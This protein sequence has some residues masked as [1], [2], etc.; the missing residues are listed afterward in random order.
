MERKLDNEN[1]RLYVK[2]LW[3][4]CL[5][6]S[7]TRFIYS[8]ENR[9]IIA[10][11]KLTYQKANKVVKDFIE[12]DPNNIKRFP[13][14]IEEHLKIIHYVYS[15]LYPKI[16]NRINNFGVQNKN[17]FDFVFSSW[18]ARKQAGWPISPKIINKLTAPT[19]QM[20]VTQML[21]KAKN[22]K[23]YQNRAEVHKFEQAPINSKLIAE[24]VEV[25]NN[26]KT[27]PISPALKYSK[28]GLDKADGSS[29]KA[30]DLKS[31]RRAEKKVE[32]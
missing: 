27:P 1:K 12:Q 6:R 25:K 4:I 32:L 9:N 13:S 8:N 17:N 24:T 19:N 16:Y 29:K 21:S 30:M 10:H 5:P 31:K 15:L 20:L 26:F 3:H 28:T 18:K 2:V 7:F 22:A 23:G 14:K 11:P